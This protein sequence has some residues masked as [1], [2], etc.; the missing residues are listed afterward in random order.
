MPRDCLNAD[1]QAVM[2][3]VEDEIL[4]FWQRDFD[5]YQRCWAH[6]PYIRRMGWSTGGGIVDIWGWEALSQ[7]VLRMFEDPSPRRQ[8]RE[9]IRLQNLVV[10]VGGDMAYV[11]FDQF[12]PDKSAGVID[13]AG[14]IRKARVLQRL[15]GGWRLVFLAY[16]NHFAEPLRA[17]MFRVDR[18]GTVGWMN[19]SA[20]QAVKQGDTFQLIAGR[21]AARHLKDTQALRAAIQR[22][23]DCDDVLETGRATI[24]ILVQQGEEDQV[25]V[26]WVVT[27]GEGSGAVLVSINSLTFAQDK[28]DA[29]AAVFGL[30]RSQQ[31]LA[32]LIA[33]G[34]DVAASSELLG[35]TANTGKTHL[36]R[37]FDKTGVRSQAAL[38]RTLLSIERPE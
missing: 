27:E 2:A 23:S 12:E 28:L 32:E 24:P 34:H 14:W 3:V 26:A 33:T 16:I 22:A 8:T 11:T 9:E 5:T 10:Q 4:A 19:Q 15:Q 30:S 17:P 35:I 37:I 20:E 21:L 18:K 31:R 38:V 1:Q 29:A 25:C 6:E 36:Q 7:R 13:R